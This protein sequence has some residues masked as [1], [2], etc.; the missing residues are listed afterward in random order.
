MA[1]K[2]FV[3]YNFFQ[4]VELPTR[5]NLKIP[6]KIH[7]NRSLLFFFT[8]APHKYSPDSVF[9]NDVSDRCVVAVARY[10]KL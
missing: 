8:N 9:A 2:S 5:P 4:L 7:I 10:T 6:E 1:L 3:T